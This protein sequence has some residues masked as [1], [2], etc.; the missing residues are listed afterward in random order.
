MTSQ[1]IYNRLTAV[2]RDV[3][4]DETLT[5]NPATNADEVEEWD[6]LSHVQL[7][8]AVEQ[9]FGVRFTSREI[10]KW[11]NVGEM[12]EALQQKLS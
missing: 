12:A 9:E 1:E 5:I 6:S 2:F 8:V 7:I 10:L 4:D 3:F 11:R